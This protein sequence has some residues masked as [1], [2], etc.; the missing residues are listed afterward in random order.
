MRPQPL[1]GVRVLDL[2]S[3]VVG[4]VCSLRLAQY[5]AE[6]I[7]LEAPGGDLMRSLGGESPTGQ[8]SGAYLHFNQGKRA[9]ALD[10]KDAEARNAV[11]AMVPHFDVVLT[12]MRTSALKRLGLNAETL[13]ELNARLIYCSI[14][15]FGPG[16]RY[17]DLPAYDSVLQGVS[18]IAGLNERRGGDAAYVPL[19]ICD[20][21][22]GEIAAGSI[23]A[24]LYERTVTGH[25]SAIEVPMFETMA[26]F[27]LQEHLAR[28]SFDPPLGAS[29]D[30]RLMDAGTRP[31]RTADG[32]ISLT[33]NTD[34]Q[35]ASF[36]RAIGRP[37]CVDDPAFKTVADRIRN[38]DQWFAIRDAELVRQST[39]HWLT[40]LAEA[41]VPAMPCH[42]LETLCDDPHLAD[43]GLMTFDDHP[44]EGRIV[45]LRPTVLRDG[46]TAPVGTPAQPL[47]WETRN[48]LIE[49]GLN[50][51]Q[52]SAM[53]DRGAAI[54]DDRS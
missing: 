32:W 1:A 6:V 24:A 10:L 23:L 34:V 11:R 45:A 2:S 54:Q 50:R 22:V 17:R 53:I 47:G 46:Q 12:N 51:A 43:V 35:F 41:D 39:A 5:G 49:G 20:H 52:V 7:K 26:A 16:G 21:V 15:G 48:I 14:T 8:H 40:V 19:L 36:M 25:G 9:L 30:K 37:E 38:L 4:P 28:A 13:R 33:T 27:V 31:V 3:V 44:T 42:S 29:G 18:G